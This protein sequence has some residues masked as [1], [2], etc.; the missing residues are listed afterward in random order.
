MVRPLRYHPLLRSGWVYGNARLIGVCNARGW[1]GEDSWVCIRGCFCIF[2]NKNTI[3]FEQY[4]TLYTV[5][6]AT[7]LNWKN[8]VATRIFCVAVQVS[9]SVSLHMHDTAKTSHFTSMHAHH[10]L[11]LVPAPCIVPCIC[12]IVERN[13]LDEPR[14]YLLSTIQAYF[15]WFQS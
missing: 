1:I 11:N 5:S 7:L 8:R 6:I 3:L 10:Q 9:E 4:R 15:T 14:P 12:V 2:V 13:Y